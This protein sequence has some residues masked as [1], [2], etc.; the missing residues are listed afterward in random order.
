MPRAPRL[1]KL[2]G[3]RG[4]PRA[5][6]QTLR[7]APPPGASSPAQG[8][9]LLPGTAPTRVGIAGGQRLWLVCTHALGWGGGVA[10]LTGWLTGCRYSRAPSSRRGPASTGSSPEV[11][12]VCLR[13]CS[14]T[15]P[16]NQCVSV[17]AARVC[18]KA[19]KEDL[20]GITKTFL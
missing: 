6:G 7:Q 3:V 10:V 17:P 5:Q 20:F 14:S 1:G 13:H 19:I 11:T 4:M 8:A 9:P 16:T 2:V 18:K 15:A 12:P